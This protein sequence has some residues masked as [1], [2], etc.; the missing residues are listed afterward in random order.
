MFIYIYSGD[1]YNCHKYCIDLDPKP[2][3]SLLSKSLIFLYH[4]ILWQY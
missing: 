3:F 2:L 1:N 4:D